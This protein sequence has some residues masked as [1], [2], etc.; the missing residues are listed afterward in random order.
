MADP[1]APLPLPPATLAPAM[2][3][4]LPHAPPSHVAPPKPRARAR[5]EPS[6]VV[7]KALAGYSSAEPPPPLGAYAVLV[8]TFS[9]VFGSLLVAGARKK[10]LPV[11]SLGDLALL[12]A[13]TFVAS[14]I[15]ARDE[16]TSFLRAPFTHLK[17][18]AGAGELEEEARGEGIQLAV[19][20]LVTCPYCLSPW[21]AATF[22]TGLAVAPKTTRT[23]LGLATVV[24]ISQTLTQVYSAL[25][26]QS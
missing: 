2:H 23:V 19:G 4:P 26:K 17:K 16:V 12:G 1:T 6:G 22:A 18:K 10:K 20:Q 8:G 5:R 13:A 25:R 21:V 15:V 24:G 9:G 3:L 14:R 7:G 11:L